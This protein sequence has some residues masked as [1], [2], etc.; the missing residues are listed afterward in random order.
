M[1]PLEPEN[2]ENKVE[3]RQV[4]VADVAVE[5]DLIQ[6]LSWD[7]SREQV[8]QKQTYQVNTQFLYER[9]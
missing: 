4:T 9:N 6:I 7:E 3:V 8:G 5:R 1:K 2:V